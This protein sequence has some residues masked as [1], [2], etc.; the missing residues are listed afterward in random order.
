[1][2]H[3]QDQIRADAAAVASG[4][5]PE[6]GRDLT[7]YDAKSLRDYAHIMYPHGDDQQYLRSDHARRFRLLMSR[8]DSLEKQAGG[9]H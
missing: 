3:D 9:A 8:A 2:A 1:M 4:H 5:C 6:T 7:G